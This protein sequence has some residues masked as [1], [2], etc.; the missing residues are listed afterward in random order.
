MAVGFKVCSSLESVL[1]PQ[2]VELAWPMALWD[3]SLSL[4]E[5]GVFSPIRAHE[6]ASQVSAMCA[7]LSMVPRAMTAGTWEKICLVLSTA[8]Y[9]TTAIFYI[10]N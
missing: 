1:R 4:E 10:K 7:Y 9:I 5:A 6:S 2:Q 8:Q 3:G